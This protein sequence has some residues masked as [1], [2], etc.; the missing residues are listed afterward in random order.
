MDP[1]PSPS[2]PSPHPAPAPTTAPSITLTHTL[3]LSA[4]H[5]L[6]SPL[7]PGPLSSQKTYGLAASPHPHLYTFHIAVQGALSPATGQ[8]LLAELV[9]DAVGMALFD[10]L[11]HKNLDEVSWFLKRPSTL[12]NLALFAWRNLGVILRVHPVK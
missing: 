4:L 5:S 10:V 11:H 3:S 2:H 1:E 9:E 12:P 6:R 8:L 7:L